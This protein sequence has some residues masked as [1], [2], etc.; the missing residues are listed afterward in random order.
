M[1][2]EDYR[3]NVGKI[4]DKDDDSLSAAGLGKVLT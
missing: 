4:A 1:G 3:K 2:A